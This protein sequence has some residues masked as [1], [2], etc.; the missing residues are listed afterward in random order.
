MLAATSV[1]AAAAAGKE[2]L[3]VKYHIY[4]LGLRVATLRFNLDFDADGYEIQSTMK[5]KGLVKLFTGA[6][7]QASVQ[8]ALRK[9][10]PIPG[11]FSAV[12]ES[13]KHGKRQQ[14]I[15]WDGKGVPQDKRSWQI[16]DYKTGQLDEAVGPGMPDPLSALLGS[17][18]KDGKGLCKGTIRVFDGRT[19]YDLDY[20]YLKQDE[21]G[22]DNPGVYR[23]EAHHCRIISTPVAGLSEKKW[24]ELKSKGNEGQ[25]TFELWMAPVVATNLNRTIF[26]PVAAVAEKDGLRSHVYLVGAAISGRALNNQSTTAKK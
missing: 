21:F 25:D 26:V 23:G 17:T 20:N 7:F 11:Q 13:S 24:R 5:T 22:A 19:I 6:E 12:T 10:S 1:S 4:A 18:L 9:F 8:G 14:D 16:G 15:T 3:F 2:Q